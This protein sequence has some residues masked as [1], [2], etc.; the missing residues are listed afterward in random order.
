VSFDTTGFSGEKL[1]TI[2]VFTSDLDRPSVVLTIHGNVLPDVLVQ[3]AQ[4]FFDEVVR[5]VPS[6]P[7]EIVVQVRE[8]SATKIT[9]VQSF[10]PY[11]KLQ[12]IEGDPSR[13]RMAV[14][15]DPQA[16]RGDLRERVVIGVSGSAE[17]TINIPV[18][19]SVKG[20]L[21]LRPQTVSFGVIEG[22]EV[23]EKSIQLDNLGTTPISVLG[24]SSDNPAVAGSVKA[25]KA[26]KNFVLTVRVDPSKVQ[27]DLRAVLTVRTDSG[28]EQTVALNVFGI[29]P[30]RS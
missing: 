11:V 22:Q 18:F 26:G 20:I 9:S 15:I 4:L 2:R 6:E 7:K 3:P 8:G 19:A 25:V 24:I 21:R 30:P 1:K 16:P 12:E 28:E 17:S 29:L 10:S 5:G 13:K 14:S 27:R 23:I